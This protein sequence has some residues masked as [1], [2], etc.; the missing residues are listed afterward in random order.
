M[1]MNCSDL[2]RPAWVSYLRCFGGALD[3]ALGLAPSHPTLDVCHRYTNLYHLYCRGVVPSRK[4]YG[5]HHQA[6]A[7]LA[8]EYTYKCFMRLTRALARQP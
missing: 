4:T 3:L 8:D 2:E 1:D 7:F 5:A 6:R